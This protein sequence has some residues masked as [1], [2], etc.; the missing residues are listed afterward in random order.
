MLI[1]LQKSQGQNDGT[2]HLNVE[3]KKDPKYAHIHLHPYPGGQDF[4]N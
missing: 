3:E 4:N 1:I 2:Y